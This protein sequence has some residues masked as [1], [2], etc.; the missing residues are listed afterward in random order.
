MDRV[1]VALA[2]LA[3]V[4]AALRLVRAYFARDKA[5]RIDAL[6]AGGAPAQGN[7]ILYFT[8]PECGE[9]R[10][11][12]EPA[13]REL[14]RQFGPRLVVDKRDAVEER[15]LAREYGVRTVPT[16]AVFDSNGTLVTINYGYASAARLAEQLG[17]AAPV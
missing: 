11:R 16:T 7:R 12:Q 1:F 13:L 17:G 4:V 3:A 15:E 9:C 8:T 10:L 5:R 6:R 2:L 14:E